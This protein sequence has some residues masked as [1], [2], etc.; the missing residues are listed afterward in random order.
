[1][2]CAYSAGVLDKFLDGGVRFD[3]CI[4]VSAG[5][6]N[7]ASFLGGQRG[8]NLRFYVD[9][10]HEPD[11]FGA[12][13]L[14]RTGDLFGL[15][16]IYATLSN[17]DGRDPLNYQGVMEN[18]AEFVIVAT[19][20]R[21]G[22]PVYFHKEDMRQDDYRI[23]MASCAI[24]A[25]SRPVRIGDARYYD[26]GVSDSIPVD[27]A[28]ADGCDRL[29]I[30][31]S[32]NRD[33]IKQPERHRLFYRTMCRRYPNI[34]RDLDTRHLSYRKSMQRM[35]DLEAEGKAFVFAPSR[36][37]AMSTYAMNE[38]ENLQLYQLGVQDYE[39][40]RAELEAFLAGEPGRVP[41]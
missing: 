14:L 40:R 36:H 26:G 13:S 12:R 9:H 17:S 21:T 31:L 33:F 2:K 29:V 8:R 7:T 11:Y 22:R 10:I 41:A 24:P 18:P 19:D 6:A 30:I 15:H 37:L 5:S 25:I 16:Y 3:Y 32:K 39:E 35:F 27:R 20:A 23:I 1:M 28:L 38:E 4:G 34:I